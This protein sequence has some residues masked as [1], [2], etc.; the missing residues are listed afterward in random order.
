MPN[1]IV[2]IDPENNLVIVMT[3]NRAGMNFSKYYAGFF[4]TIVDGLVK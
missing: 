2:R 1:T 3:R 4:E